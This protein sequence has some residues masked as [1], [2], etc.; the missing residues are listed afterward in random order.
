MLTD[1]SEQKVCSNVFEMVVGSADDY[2]H[3]RMASRKKGEDA[4][5]RTVTSL[6]Q[7]ALRV[8]THHQSLKWGLRP[9]N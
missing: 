8:A 2:F 4:V 1:I 7:L 9:V 5:G 3:E 6:F